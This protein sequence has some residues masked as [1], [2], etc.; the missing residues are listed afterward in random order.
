MTRTASLVAAVLLLTAVAGSL[1]AQPPPPAPLPPSQPSPLAYTPPPPPPPPPAP[2]FEPAPPGAAAPGVLGMGFFLGVELG[3]LKPTVTG[4]LVNE[5]P[6]GPLG[7]KLAVPRASLDWVV[8]PAIE[9]GYKLPCGEAFVA[10]YRFLTSEGNAVVG[11]PADPTQLRSRLD[12]QFFDLDYALAPYEFAPRYELNS[13][14]GVRVADVFFDSRATDAAGLQ[15]AS[16][17]FFGAGIHGR[18]EVKRS[19]ALLPGLGIFGALDGSALVGRT[20][21][22]FHLENDFGEV[23]A[24]SM[25]QH[26]QRTVGVVQLQ[27]GLSYAPPALPGLQFVTGYEYE[28]IFAA[29]DLGPSSGDVYSQGWFIRARFDF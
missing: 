24:S 23:I 2:L 9:V 4:G 15:Q 17:D 25:K 19:I 28:R 18:L 8:S 27:V 29:G 13:R 21:Q 26:G 22:K 20:N 7:E 1:P 6:L 12:V 5:M 11:G 10:T 3:F 16:N 14:L